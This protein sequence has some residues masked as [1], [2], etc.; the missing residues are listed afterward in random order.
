MGRSHFSRQSARCRL[1]RRLPEMRVTWF[2]DDATLV[3]GVSRDLRHAL[4]LSVRPAWLREVVCVGEDAMLYLQAS[5]RDREISADR[6]ALHTVICAWLYAVGQGETAFISQKP[7]L[8]ACTVRYGGEDTDLEEVARRVNLSVSDVIARHT[9]QTY[10]VDAAG[11]VPG[12]AYLEGL[13]D[14]LY[15]P[16]KA[17]PRVQVFPGAVAIAAGYTG[18]YP[19]A[20]AGGWWILGTLV[21]PLPG[22]LWQ[23]D[24]D[25][26]ARLG[27]GDRVVFRSVDA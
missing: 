16:R 12:F 22:A 13:P 2:G 6:A 14:S 26:P 24:A 18:I 8:H 27:F 15:L 3:E 10:I 11:F 7:K 19:S 23:W 20:S 21:D 17:V 4:V 25:P 9:S 1:A 5:P